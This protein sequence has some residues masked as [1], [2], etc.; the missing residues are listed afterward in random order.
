MEAK[1]GVALTTLSQEIG[2][3]KSTVH[4][5]ITTLMNYGYVEQDPTMGHYKLG[6]KL[7]GLSNAVLETIDVRRTSKPF[8]KELNA[9]TNEVVH[10][11]VLNSGDVVY[12]DKIE[13][14]QSITINSRIG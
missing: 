11:V 10:L 3:H 13:S 4:R 14:D 6:I 5:L 8:I 2:L 1:G 7:I 12:I 9:L